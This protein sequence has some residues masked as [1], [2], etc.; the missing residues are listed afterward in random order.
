[1]FRSV[2][3]PPSPFL[4]H[5]EWLVPPPPS[6]IEILEDHSRTIL[7]QND[8]PDLP[9]RWSLNPYRG[10]VHACAYCY[11]R[12]THEYLSLGAGTD[13][14]TRIVVKRLAPQLLEATFRRPSWKGELI[15][16]SGN[17][18][19]YQPLEARFGLTRACL[20]I[21]ARYR[22]PIAV[23]TKSAL[24]ERDID[25][26]AA[27]A[28]SAAATVTVSVA[29]TNARQARRLEPYAPAPA[30]RFRTVHL[31]AQAGIPVGVS[32]APIVPGLNDRQIPGVLQA[33]REAG[34]S[35]AGVGLVRLKGSVETVFAERL[36]EA[37]PDAAAAVLQRIRRAHRPDDESWRATESLFRLWKR[38]LGYSRAPGPP[39]PSPFRRP[40]E[41][42][43]LSLFPDPA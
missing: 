34:A 16:F 28:R 22:N 39:R 40:P 23:L 31:L 27:H 6:S 11:A 21:C 32:L 25:L 19:C 3:N 1:M 7:S 4:P 29:F 17:T 42:G 20:E 9:F 24:I 15:L 2:S 35:W 5:L 18:D 41:P 12:V 30:R 13:F 10:C 33:A 43:Q 38:R 37:F 14:D 36:H 8:S 26:L